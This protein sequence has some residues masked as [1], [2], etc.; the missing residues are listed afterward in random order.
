MP[1]NSSVKASIL[2]EI[3]SASS[4]AGGRIVGG[5]GPHRH[6]SLGILREFEP[7]VLH[8]CAQRVHARARLG[9]DLLAFD[10]DAIE[11]V[12]ASERAGERFAKLRDKIRHAVAEPASDARRKSVRLRV[13]GPAEVVEIDPIV[14][15]RPFGDDGVEEFQRRGH[16]PAVVLAEDEDVETGI[17]HGQTELKRLAR[18]GA[19]IARRSRRPS[20]RARRIAEG[21]RRPRQ[22]SW[23]PWGC[24]YS[25]ARGHD[26]ARLPPGQAAA[27]GIGGAFMID[28]KEHE[29]QNRA[30]DR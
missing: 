6:H 8:L 16:A 11:V 14:G 15:R 24:R 2:R 4:R 22:V 19:T 25:V 3:G 27:R 5:L 12:F 9:L 20:P 23:A 18:A 21:P 1:R 10:A 13:V 29:V 28:N 17:G 30:D 7:V 26:C